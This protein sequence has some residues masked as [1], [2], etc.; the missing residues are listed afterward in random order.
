M[1]RRVR[2]GQLETREGR[3]KLKPAKKPIFKKIGQGI[4]RLSSQQ[5]QWDVGPSS[6]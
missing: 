5:D 1:P 2:G 3:L 4:T 6:C